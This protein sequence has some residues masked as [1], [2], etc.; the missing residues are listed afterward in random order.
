MK[1]GGKKTTKVKENYNIINNTDNKE[2]LGL[3]TGLKAY[4][5]KPRVDGEER[6]ERPERTER[7]P[8]E[9]REPRE[10]RDAENKKQ[11]NDQQSGSP[12]KPYE[13]RE[14]LFY[15]LFNYFRTNN[16]KNKVTKNLKTEKLESPLNKPPTKPN[17]LN[18][19]RPMLMLK[20]INLSPHYEKIYF[21][22]RK[23]T[24][25]L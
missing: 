17:P 14:V 21:L 7:K 2:L 22:M 9:A 23:F 24:F 12:K 15:L 19:P 1:T 5:E 20:T 8:R 4:S 10:P 11:S 3:R 18:Q 16:S 13:K 6:P 25:I